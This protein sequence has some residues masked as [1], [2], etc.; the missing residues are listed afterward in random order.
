[1]L[2]CQLLA[3]CPSWLLK[4]SGKGVQG[5]LVDIINLYFG[6]GVFPEGLKKPIIVPQ[7]AVVQGLDAQP[8]ACLI[9]LWLA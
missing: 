1:M 3:P 9:P 7:G 5:P 2:L 6:N 4:A 8:S